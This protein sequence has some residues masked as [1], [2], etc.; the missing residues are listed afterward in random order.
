MGPGSLRATRS[1]TGAWVGWAPALF[2]LRAHRPALGWDGPRL[3]SRSALIDRRL[4]GMGPGSLRVPRSSTG[5][6]VGWAPALFAL[7]AH[8]PAL[9]WDGPRLSSR[10][11]LIDRRRE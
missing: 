7:R 8:R 10:Y 1:S 6:W 5:A 4:G 9:G 2:A 3:S 11:A